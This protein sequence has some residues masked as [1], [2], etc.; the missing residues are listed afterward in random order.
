MRRSANAAIP[1]V[2]VLVAALV[3]VVLGR[4]DPSG[5]ATAQVTVNA[6]S[7]SP[8]TVNIGVGDTVTWTVAQG[9]GLHTV[10]ANGG[11]FDSDL[12]GAGEAFSHTFDTPGTYPYFCEVH[13][14]SMSGVVIVGSAP[15]SSTSTS[16]TSTSS[17]STSTSTSS[18]ST[19]STSSTSTSS[20]STSSTSTTSTTL[21]APDFS[22][23]PPDHPFAAEITWLAQEGI[24][25]GFGDGTFRP[26]ESIT[27]QAL[28]AFIWRMQG[29]PSVG[30]G[31]PTFN[32]VP[33]G[34]PFHEAISWLAAEGITA[35]YDDG[36][37]H[38]GDPITRQA[39]AAFLYRLDGEP[40]GADP[41]CGDDFSDVD[42]GNPFC[43]EI[44][45]LV[46]E[47][48][49]NG[50]GDGTFGPGAAITRQAMAAF[51]YRYST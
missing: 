16:S 36:G 37:F 31:A 21:P 47:G 43:G 23:V 51:L 1:L 40:L 6:A 41:P 2:M 11:A 34:H 45:W 32:D 15:T 30:P 28:A 33:P 9:A 26:T 5:A 49:A 22:D 35:G 13:G 25:T 3:V 4:A 46:A 48:I 39:M 27:R 44:T 29:E 24:T 10:T 18:T 38:P 20:T 19:S 17:S 42:A 50:F 12:I 14:Q 7:F 8:A